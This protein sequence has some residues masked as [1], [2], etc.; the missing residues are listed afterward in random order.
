MSVGQGAWLNYL[1]AQA[2]YSQN[3]NVTPNLTKW[4]KTTAQNAN[5]QFKLLRAQ[6]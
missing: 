2:G 5:A 6:G 4:L 3:S 1:V